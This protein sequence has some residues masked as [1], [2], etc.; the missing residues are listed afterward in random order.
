ML[1][2]NKLQRGE[3]ELEPFN[4]EAGRAPRRINM[5]EDEAHIEEKRNFRKTFYSMAEN[6]SQLVLRLEKAEE[7]NPKG[8]GSTHGNGREEAPPSSSG[9]EG[10]SSSHHH[11]CRNS[12]DASKKPT[13]KLDVKFDIPIFSGESTAEKLNNWIRQIEV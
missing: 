7:R 10:S 11:N 5:D 4:P 9:S 13:L 2:R 1:I 12:K 8:Q 3:G 6:I